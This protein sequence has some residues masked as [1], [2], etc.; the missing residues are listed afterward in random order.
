LERSRRYRETRLGAFDRR[1]REFCGI[2]IARAFSWHT[3]LKDDVDTTNDSRQINGTVD[4]VTTRQSAI[5]S[6]RPVKGIRRAVSSLR[7]QV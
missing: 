5:E 4:T 1:S 2:P 6:A 7:V 3:L